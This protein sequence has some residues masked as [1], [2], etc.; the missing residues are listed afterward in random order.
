MNN[1]ECRNKIVFFRRMVWSMVSNDVDMSRTTANGSCL[2]SSFFLMI[3]ISSRAA[4]Y[5]FF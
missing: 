1:V 5:V 4:N 2:A 3:S